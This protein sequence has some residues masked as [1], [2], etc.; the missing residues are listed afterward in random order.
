MKFVLKF[1]TKG[2]F[3]IFSFNMIFMMW[4]RGERHKV[5][6]LDFLMGQQVS[7]ILS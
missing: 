4:P 7:Q 3:L 6:S 1:K 2:L 5:D